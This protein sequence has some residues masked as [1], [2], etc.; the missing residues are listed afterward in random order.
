M[1]RFRLYIPRPSARALYLRRDS[2]VYQQGLLCLAVR[3]APER[4]I[5]R[6]TFG[7]VWMILNAFRAIVAGWRFQLNGDVTGKLCLKNIDL[8]EFG[9][10][11]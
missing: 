7:S 11:V 9:V 2:D 5:L 4:D 1:T 8:D 6:I 10:K 3:S